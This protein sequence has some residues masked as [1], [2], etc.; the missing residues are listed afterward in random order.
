MPPKPKHLTK[1]PHIT[2]AAAGVNYE[3]LDPIKRLAQIRAAQTAEN[4]AN[5]GNQEVSASRGESA[6]VWEEADAYRAMVI[7][8]LGTKNLVA[9]EMQRL[10]GKTYYD[11]IAQDTVGTI[12][13]DLIVV[14]AQPQVITAYFAVG[15][16]DWFTDQT[17]AT[18]LI[19]GWASACQMAGVVWGGGE[20]PTL[21]NIVE[22]GTI[23]LAGSAVGTIQPKE[24]LVLGDKLAA[25]DAIVLVESNGI[26]ANGLTLA[27]TI[28]KQLKKGYLTPLENG[29]TYGE[30][31]LQP[32]HIYAGLVRD[33]FEASVDIHY[34]VHI[35]GHGWRKLMRANQ[36]FCYVLNQ[37]PEPS[38]L[39]Q[40]L[41]KH[42]GS[43]DTEMFGNFNMGAGFALFVPANEVPK[44]IQIAKKNHR[45]KAWQGGRVEEVSKQVIIP[46]RNIVFNDN[47]L[48]VRA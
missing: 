29:Q 6:Y 22:P 20:T 36:R 34:M 38:P 47:D 44:I 23:D 14:G 43:N 19:E 30:A 45:L 16:S 2:Y 24:R 37:L 26:H 17:R 35:T 12:I 41:Q 4:F 25:G 28:A 27:R 10:T 15:D 46:G 9:D 21:R 5:S 32:S 40:F 7:E 31:L 3:T 42:S 8:G 48:A 33:V 11:A 1:T 39:F 13:N 18:A